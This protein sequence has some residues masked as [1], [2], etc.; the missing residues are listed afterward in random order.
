MSLLQ[1]IMRLPD[2]S[3]AIGVPVRIVIPGSSEKSLEATTDQE[4]AVFH[5]FNIHSSAPITL[6]V[7]ILQTQL[8]TFSNLF[9][10]SFNYFHLLAPKGDRRWPAGEENN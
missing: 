4:G 7:S 10:F 2:G 8:K 9:L 6:E 5:S 1:V 3:P